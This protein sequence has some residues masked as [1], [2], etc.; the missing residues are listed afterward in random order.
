MLRRAIAALFLGSAVLSA[1]ETLPPF[2][3]EDVDVVPMDTE[4]VLE[5]QTVLVVDGRIAAIG[6]ADTVDVPDGALRVR[7]R[8]RYLMPGLADMHVHCWTE[9]EHLL[10]LANG[11]T[12][13]RNMWG[14]PHHLEWRRRAEAGELEGP[15]V[16]T[17]GPL[18]DGDPPHWPGSVV[19]T[20]PEAARAEV[21]RQKAA[22]YEAV[23]VYSRLS[24]ECYDAIVEAAREHG[25]R[26]DGHVP[27]AVGIERALEA[28]QDSIEH[29]EGYFLWDGA[30]PAGPYDGWVRATLE[31]GTWNCVTLVVIERLSFK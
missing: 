15:T 30:P 17:T 20:D 2:A 31:A 7:G 12:T 11:V 10:F 26:V 19:V 18:I 4:R 25:L 24:R 1:Q 3:F 13:V 14:A 28:R 23:K 6:P 8:G 22:G 29:L 5:D 27:G 16:Y 9:E 21:A